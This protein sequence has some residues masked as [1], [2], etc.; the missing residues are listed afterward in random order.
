[1]SISTP[2]SGSRK[3]ASSAWA[4]DLEAARCL[5]KLFA[6]FR[7]HIVECPLFDFSRLRTGAQVFCGVTPTSAREVSSIVQLAGEHAVPLR[8]RG[9]GHA[10]NGS[11]LPRHAELVVHTRGLTEA[12]Y[13]PDGSVSV[14]AGAVL[15]SVDAWL[16]TKG[17][18]LPVLNDGYA[19]PSVGGYVAAGGFGPGSA[20]A[21]GFWDNVAEITM[22]DGEGRVQRIRR[23]APLFPW[24]FGSMGQLGIIVRAKLD[25]V[26]RAAATAGCRF[27]PAGSGRRRA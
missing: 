15:W 16:R 23:E 17:C 5:Q 6:R 25:I 12:L 21:G 13:H 1:M 26:A 18:S 24:L 10:L 2:V 22:V 19:G 4:T 14:G 9:N 11:S 7:A 3:L 27:R 8:T 20:I